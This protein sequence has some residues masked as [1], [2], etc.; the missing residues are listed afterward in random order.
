MGLPLP[1]SDDLDRMAHLQEAQSRSYG[2][3]EKSVWDAFATGD[4]RSLI[5][6]PQFPQQ[7]YQ[8]L[9]SFVQ[10][11]LERLDVMVDL[12]HLLYTT[13]KGRKMIEGIAERHAE[14]HCEAAAEDDGLGENY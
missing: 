11:E 13:A 5:W 10:D 7:R 3:L 1:L 8:D 2:V 9:R 14:L 6:C 12:I 4:P